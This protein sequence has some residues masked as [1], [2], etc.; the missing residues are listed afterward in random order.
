[1]ARSQHMYWTEVRKL[2]L[3]NS[4]LNSVFTACAQNRLSTNRPSFAA[5][6]GSQSSRN[7]D[8]VDFLQAS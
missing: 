7:A 3:A 5:A 8:A 6:I 2:E 1:M 4:R